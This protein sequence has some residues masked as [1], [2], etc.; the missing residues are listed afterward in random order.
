VIFPYSVTP[1]LRFWW[2]LGGLVVGRAKRAV[3]ILGI[4]SASATLVVARV[5]SARWPLLHVAAVFTGSLP[6]LAAAVVGA[7]ALWRTGQR[8]AALLGTATLLAGA[9]NAVGDARGRQWDPLQPRP[10]R[11]AEGGR[12]GA[13]LLDGDR[14]GAGRAAIAH[15]P[16]GAEVRWLARVHGRSP[17]RHVTGSMDDHAKNSR[18]YFQHD[19]GSEA[20]LR[21][22]SNGE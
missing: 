13:H 12:I 3:R 9:L 8:A 22:S 5:P 21:A 4:L 14:R 18:R 19:G 2:L 11:P 10:S 6:G 7:L 17:A 20:A 16:A 15:A 1:Y